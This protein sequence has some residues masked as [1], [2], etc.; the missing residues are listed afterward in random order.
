[1]AAGRINEVMQQLRR[2]VLLQEGAGLTDGQLLG[3]FID[4]RD[5]AAFAA[6]VRRHG[7]MV[8][9]VCRRLLNQHDAE[10]AFQATFLVLVRKATAIVPRERVANWLYG[11]AYQTALQARRTAARRR[12]REKQVAQV[13]EPA[14]PERDLCRDLQPLLHQELSRLPAAYREVIVLSDLEGKH[15]RE[16]ARHLG[17]PEGTVASRLARARAM[18]A[19]RLT[20]R[21][22]ALSVGTL[23]AVLSHD[24]ASASMP[25][26]LVSSTIQAASL[27]APGQAA[28]N[29][30]I[31]AK[32]AALT[33][34]VLR[35]MFLT[36]LRI[37]A[38]AVL[39]V[40]SLTGGAGLIYQTQ[41]AQDTTGTEKPGLTIQR[42]DEPAG[43]KGDKT[44]EV[45]R[46]IGE[47]EKQIQSLTGEVKALQQKLNSPTAHPPA[48]TVAKTFQLRHRSVDEVAQ[49]LWELY[50]NKTGSEVRIGKHGA[51]DTLIIVAS[52]N[53]LAV[54]EAI[55]TQ[56]EN[57]P[58]KGQNEGKVGQ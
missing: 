12:G 15:R 18:L 11:V 30:V 24:A 46:R 38:A 58:K 23:A 28:A 19:G 51:T 21:G 7:P 10:D 8:W 5:D 14:V 53:D 2:T 32:V 44:P 54:V 29:G 47:L 49:T 41:A 57:L 40:A 39:V 55:I 42:A 33:G 48:K 22:V 52:P 20:R 6:L 43:E 37:A 45:E 9:G 17:L 50:R 36:K 34:G 25:P 3:C 13:P 1:M 16:I 27:F 26:P 4:H 35:A 31:S 56:L